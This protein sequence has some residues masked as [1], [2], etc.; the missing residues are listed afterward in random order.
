MIRTPLSAP[1]AATLAACALGAAAFAG[2]DTIVID[3][4][5]VDFA[6]PAAVAIVYD[7]VVAA[8]E[9]VCTTIYIDE[10]PHTV[11]Y[12][13]RVRLYDKCVAVTIEDA[14]SAADLQP[15]SATHAARDVEAYQVA[16]Q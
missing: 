1:F 9:A 11:S 8:S 15:L 16:A 13:E 10:M 12:F 6:D 2:E 14:I 3:V 4:S 5:E 7:Q